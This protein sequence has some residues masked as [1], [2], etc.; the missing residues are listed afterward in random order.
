MGL[1]VGIGV[2]FTAGYAWRVAEDAERL[3]LALAATQQVLEREQRL[4]ALGGLAAAAAHE[5]GTPLAT[6]QVVAKEML[7]AANRKSG[8]PAVAEDA[9]PD[10]AA[11]RTLPGHPQAAVPAPEDGDAIYAEVGLKALLEEVVQPHRGFDLDMDCRSRRA[12]DETA[13]PTSAACPRSS[14]ACPPSSRTPPI[15]PPSGSSRR[16][17]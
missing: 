5:L 7:R 9:R 15:S 13:P 2:I 1:A 14:T 11:G 12:S 10:P 16:P 8:D 3:A 4:A 6:I 17:R